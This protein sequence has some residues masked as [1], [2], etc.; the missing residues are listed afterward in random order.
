MLIYTPLQ[1]IRQFPDL[2]PPLP[3]LGIVQIH[4]RLE[5]FAVPF[6]PQMGQF[7]GHDVAQVFRR[8]MTEIQIDANSPRPDIAGSPA[9]FHLTH[10][11]AGLPFAHQG[12][13][14]LK[15]GWQKSFHLALQ[16]QVKA[17]FPS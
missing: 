4:P 8:Q 13:A 7:M 14:A 2:L 12:A 11:P 6:L 3:P 15:D 1:H 10:I 9:G 5:R 17:L 16:P